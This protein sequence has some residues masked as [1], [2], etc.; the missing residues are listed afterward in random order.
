MYFVAKCDT[1]EHAF[2]VTPEDQEA[3]VAQ[4]QNTCPGA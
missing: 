3:N 2:G 1:G 4:F